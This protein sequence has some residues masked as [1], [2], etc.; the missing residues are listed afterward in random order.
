MP[1]Y[2]DRLYR[3]YVTA[4]T[5]SLAPDTLAGLKGRRPHLARLIADHF[6]PARG[7]AILELC[8]GH[9]ALLHFAR[10]AGYANM[11]GVDASPAQ[12]EA[13]KR[14]GISGVRQGDLWAALREQ[15]SSSLDAV[16]AF[17]VLEHLTKEELFQA[18]DE[19]NRA[20][21][22]GGSWI[23]HVPNALSPFVGGVRYGDL[24]HEL[25]FTPE[26]LTQLFLTTGFRSASF[27][28]DEPIAHG[29]K[30]GLRWL[31]W[32]GLRAAMRFAVAIETGDARRQPL[33]QN[34]LAVAVK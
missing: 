31:L 29:V 9:G 34:L 4:A 13:A 3:H 8:C 10:E 18:A 6:P 20:L 33:T 17:D 2:R 5:T 7:A 14:L 28:E 19:V 25:A 12:V 22:P 24:T 21:K 27:H 23:V 15:T 1:T 26:S 11:A 16:V 32:K 30:S